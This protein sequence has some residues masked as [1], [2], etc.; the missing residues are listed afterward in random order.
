[1]PTD[2]QERFKVET[3]LLKPLPGRR[4]DVDPEEEFWS[5][6]REDGA[7]FMQALSQQSQVMTGKR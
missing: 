2:P 4:K 6:A 3:Q 7:A 5:T 1:M